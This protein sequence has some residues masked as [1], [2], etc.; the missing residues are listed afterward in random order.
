MTLINVTALNESNACQHIRA[1]ITRLCLSPKSPKVYV[2]THFNN[3]CC[4]QI[5]FRFFYSINKKQEMAKIT[6]ALSEVLLIV[7]EI[8]SLMLWFIF[9]FSPF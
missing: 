4:Y 2:K 3:Y 6:S 7:K 1:I 8:K 9:L 5:I